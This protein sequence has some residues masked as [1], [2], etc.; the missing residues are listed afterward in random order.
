MKEGTQKNLLT[1]VSGVDV[2][3]QVEFL[4]RYTGCPCFRI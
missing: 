3:A 4:L 2:F 1:A